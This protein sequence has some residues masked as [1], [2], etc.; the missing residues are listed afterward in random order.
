MK[1]VRSYVKSS[2]RLQA[3][4]YGIDCA[5][6]MAVAVRSRS[7][8][9]NILDIEQRGHFSSSL[10]FFCGRLRPGLLCIVLTM[11]KLQLLLLLLL[12]LLSGFVV[13]GCSAGKYKEAYRCVD[14]L[15]IWKCCDRCNSCP[16]GRYT[17]SADE[18]SCNACVSGRYQS[19]T[20][21]SSCSY[22]ASGR[23]EGSA[24]QTSCRSSCPA[25]RY[26][27]G[28]GKTSVAN[29]C[30]YCA[31]GRYEGSTAQTSCTGFCPAGKYGTGVGKVSETSGCNNCVSGRYQ[32]SAGRSSCSGS[33]PAGKYGTRDGMAFE[34]DACNACPSGRYSSG[35]AQTSCASE[36]PAGSYG[37]VPGMSTLEQ[38]CFACPPNTFGSVAGL[39]VCTGCDGHSASGDG[40]TVCEFPTGA[41]SGQPTSAPSQPTSQ[42]TSQ[43]SREPTGQPSVIPSGQPTGNPS[44][45]PSGQP[46]SRPSRQ[47][48]SSP[49]SVPSSQP[50]SLPSSEPSSLPSEVPS[51]APSSRPTSLCA[52]GHYFVYCM[53]SMEAKA[54]ACGCIKCGFGKYNAYAGLIGETSCL[55]CARGFYA[56]H[57]GSSRCKAA[58]EGSFVSGSGSMNFQICPQ[59]TYA[60][61]KGDVACTACPP[62]RITS[63]GGAIHELDCVSPEW[64]FIQGFI[65]IGFALLFCYQYLVRGRFE[66]IAFQRKVRVTRPLIQDARR[67]TSLLALFNSKENAEIFWEWGLHKARN[68]IVVFVL[69][70]VFLFAIIVTIA[71]EMGGVAF[72]SMI[73][74]KSMRID[75]SF[76]DKIGE[77]LSRVLKSLDLEFIYRL[78]EPFVEMIRILSEWKIDFAAVKV[79]CPGAS[80]PYRLMLNV[81][82]IGLVVVFIESDIQLFKV[83]SYDALLFERTR[84]VFKVVYVQWNFMER[85]ESLYMLFGVG[86][87]T[88]GKALLLFLVQILTR[89][90]IFQ[91]SL[92]YAMSLVRLSSFVADRRYGIPINETSEACNSVVGFEMYDLY[93]AIGTSS[94]V[95]LL[96]VPSI[97][98]VSK[99]MI[100]GIPRELVSALHDDD[101]ATDGGE[102]KRW[103][104]FHRF[105]K[106]ASF[107]APDLWWS[108]L[109]GTGTQMLVNDIPDNTGMKARTVVSC[110]AEKACSFM[111]CLQ[112]FH[113]TGNFLN[114][115]TFSLGV[116]DAEPTRNARNRERQDA[117]N[118]T[119]CKHHCQ[120]VVNTEMGSMAL[121]RMSDV[122]GLTPIWELEAQWK[123]EE[124]VRGG[125]GA[126]SVQNAP[127]A[128]I[129]LGKN[130][131]I[132]V[133]RFHKTSGTFLGSHV[134]AIGTDETVA[135]KQT[136]QLISCLAG[137]SAYKS[138]SPSTD[139]RSSFFSI[140][141]IVGGNDQRLPPGLPEDFYFRKQ[142]DISFST[143]A[144]SG[145]Y[146]I[147]DS[148]KRS[149]KG[150]GQ[151]KVNHTKEIKKK[152]KKISLAGLRRFNVYFDPLRDMEGCTA[153]SDFMSSKEDGNELY[154]LESD[155]RNDGQGVAA[156]VNNFKETGT[157]VEKE[158]R[159]EIKS[160]LGNILNTV[161]HVEECLLHT[162]TNATG[163]S[164]SN[165]T[166]R[167][168][169]LSPFVE[170]SELEDLE[171]RA[172]RFRRMPSY[173]VLCH[174]EFREL[175]HMLRCSKYC[176][177]MLY[178]L[179]WIP[180]W[181]LI[182]FGFGHVITNIGCIAF[183]AVLHKYYTFAW[184]CV[185]Y[186]TEE[187]VDA[188]EIRQ[189]IFRGSTV[190]SH[191]EVL[192]R[193]RQHT[194]NTM[195]T[196]NMIYDEQCKQEYIKEQELLFFYEREHGLCLYAMLATRA[197]MM[198]L[199]PYMSIVSIF[200]TSTSAFPLF[201]KCEDLDEALGSLVVKKPFAI[202]RQLITERLARERSI[203]NAEVDT[204]HAHDIPNPELKM[205]KI[206]RMVPVAPETR[207]RIDQLNEGCQTYLEKAINQEDVVNEWEVNLLGVYVYVTSSRLIMFCIGV[208]RWAASVGFLYFGEAY[209][210]TL[211]IVAALVFAPYCIVLSIPILILIGQVLYITDA[212]IQACFG[213]ISVIWNCLRC[214]S[215]SSSD[216]GSSGGGSARKVV[217]I[218]CVDVNGGSIST[219][220]KHCAQ[221]PGTSVRVKMTTNR[222]DIEM[223]TLN[224]LTTD[225]KTPVNRAE[226]SSTS[227]KTKDANK[228]A[229][230]RAPQRGM[231]TTARIFHPPG[232]VIPS[233]TTETAEATN[234]TKDAVAATVVSAEVRGDSSMQSGRGRGRG[235]AVGRGGRRGGPL[236]RPSL[237][238]AEV[239]NEDETAFCM[240]GSF[241]G[242]GGRGSKGR[243]GRGRGGRGRG[244]RG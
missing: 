33:C 114:P 32:S 144:T 160:L 71:V 17:S 232:D 154:S 190:W 15:G 43:P 92:Q 96:C 225:I 163:M 195:V 151:A 25:G 3:T 189:K 207:T 81:C 214:G 182:F 24:A 48:T 233:S 226:M 7:S 59:G 141:V 130:C 77:Y 237:N 216:G 145:T 105:L 46:T 229:D 27:T 204:K 4:A 137:I 53:D 126:T 11:R 2:L 97:Y 223:A 117:I 134:F 158:K 47:P 28:G 148:R 172:Q 91:T 88:Y 210:D 244:G 21:Q 125:L 164:I 50:S 89:A 143:F 202:S 115:K 180:S 178:V 67:V 45:N 118:S 231:K 63:G 235:G 240:D 135:F 186:W 12:L 13:H 192:H 156:D 152:S 200:V 8:E 84:M 219:N 121:L 197:C 221:G 70:F 171:W 239:E 5:L 215:D 16:V 51:S 150:Q 110:A 99:I 86:S 36:C 166:A 181:L 201:V 35:T 120:I 177:Y 58:P 44:V 74:F 230:S 68:M 241:D 52:P 138:M 14:C 72:K 176:P 161:V 175:R 159:L 66:R 85:G 75:F 236:A 129:R 37:N 131:D 193:M 22:C 234:I 238:N 209:I 18:S 23:Y 123:T 30:S 78:M 155:A 168:Y 61:K 136:S 39:T 76:V 174:R 57:L 243:G 98:E 42:P 162:D 106:T 41:P 220:G 187:A 128:S 62:G 102:F 146:M 173:S 107:F 199:I 60:A 185:G 111:T 69:L 34:A 139:N 224:P 109:V 95:W 103:F 147:I 101:K 20:G 157:V 9:T 212:E 127:G 132:V 40:H 196:E 79:T 31:S 222:K 113:E 211:V 206:G 49:S 56:D 140:A 38:A 122:I 169:V 213:W 116:L 112:I 170:R 73:M 188:F 142:N 203:R 119:R 83:L 242:R 55:D 19:S 133:V 124:L 10:P 149:P 218:A 64:N 153:A 80:G 87:A 217:D 26:G 179:L 93:L 94:V 165:G 198:Q 29:G 208:C 6:C 183:K 205:H 108:F 104:G 194:G 90:D 65:A 184:L 167:K 100:P 227:F 82:V 191:P 228:M 54:D 1:T